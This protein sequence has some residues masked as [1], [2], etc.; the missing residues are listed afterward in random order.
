MRTTFDDLDDAHQAHL[1]T[2]RGAFDD[3]R[4][5]EEDYTEF[6]DTHGL[7]PLTDRAHRAWDW[8][9]HDED[10][11]GRLAPLAAV[12]GFCAWWM[13]AVVARNPYVITATV[14]TVGLAVIAASIWLASGYGTTRGVRR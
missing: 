7:D 8:R 4:W 10:G 14:A 12:A 3:H 2:S 11:H 1:D 9:T 5:A 13:L 6:C